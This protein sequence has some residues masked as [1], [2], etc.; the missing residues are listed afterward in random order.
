MKTQ[1]EA[2]DSRGGGLTPGLVGTQLGR[3]EQ[4]HMVGWEFGA[5]KALGQ[6]PRSQGTAKGPT[7]KGE[8]AGAA[9]AP[10]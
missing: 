1:R 2:G 10:L 5:L 4:G 7:S 3:A 6:N 8:P 9:A